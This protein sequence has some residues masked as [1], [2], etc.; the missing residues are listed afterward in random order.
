MP[1]RAG[2]I[3]RRPMKSTAVITMSTEDIVSFLKNWHAEKTPL[4]IAYQSPKGVAHLSFVGTLDE[5]SHRLAF[6][7]LGSAEG[8]SVIFATEE[9]ALVCCT[10]VGQDDIGPERYFP[11]RYERAVSIGGQMTVFVLTFGDAGILTLVELAS[12]SAE[13]KN[14]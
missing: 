8:A 10:D 2:R 14:V 13:V 1:H 5:I 7:S 4:G 12:E 3:Y 6:R 9:I 11:R